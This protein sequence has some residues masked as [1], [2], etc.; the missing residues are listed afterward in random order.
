MSN[1]VLISVIVPCYKQAHFL[2][3]TLQSVLD[4]SYSDWECL[5]VN[6][7]SP[8]NT[9]AI[10][11]KWIE[12]DARFKYLHKENGGL[13]S[14][15]NAGINVA[16]GKYI[17][18]LDSDDKIN[19]LYLEKIV[20]HFEANPNLKVIS[21]RIQFFGFKNTEYV[22]PEYEYKKILVQNCFAHCSAFKKED[23]AK[24]GGY[25]ENLKSFEDWDFWIRLL[26]ENSKVYKIPELM[27]IYRKHPEGSMSDRFRND[28]NFYFGLY[29]YIYNKNKALYDKQFGNPI[30]AYQES[31]ELKKFN[32]KIKRTFLFKIY[33]F[34]KSKI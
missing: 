9:E 20:N 16:E 13:P 19:M 4:Q 6:D 24:I 11:K 8:D 18:P 14:A 17:L 23:W 2:D 12:K 33:H 15:R 1:K 28:P 3:E 31:M 10:A 26:D 30:L 7:G 5:I 22:L 34:I 27:F 29:D 25:D 32:N 21:S